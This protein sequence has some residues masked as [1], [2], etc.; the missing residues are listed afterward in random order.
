MNNYQPDDNHFADQLDAL[1]PPGQSTVGQSS[2]PAL[3][4]ALRLAQAP[5]PVMSAEAFAR[6]QKRVEQTHRMRHELKVVKTRKP[7]RRFSMPAA[8]VS[9]ASLV[10]MLMIAGLSPV[11]AESL[12]GEI[13]YPLKQTYEYAELAMAWTPAQRAEVHMD[14]AQERASEA[15]D[16]VNRGILDT[17]LFDSALNEMQIAKHNAGLARSADLDADIL[18][19]Q[20]NLNDVL[21]Y[22][23]HTAM[24]RRLA[25]DETIRTMVSRIEIP[26]GSQ[27]IFGPEF[28]DTSLNT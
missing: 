8:W 20:S 13:L 1:L 5:M 17:A 3:D 2:D 19:R 12:P 14:H 27:P 18:G 21:L 28:F 4:A 11:A 10:F 7:P 25:P 24:F 15:L 9:V 26:E 23:L 16:L 6:I 22:V